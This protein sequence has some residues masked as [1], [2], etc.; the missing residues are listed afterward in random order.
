MRGKV[1]G[2][3]LTAV[4]LRITPAYAGKSFSSDGTSVNIE[5]HP[6]LCGE[7]CQESTPR[8]TTAGSPPPM[9][10]KELIDSRPCPVYRITPAYAGK[11]GVLVILCYF[12]WDPPR[13]CG[14]K[15]QLG[16]NSH[17]NRGSPPP[18]RG[19][20]L[21]ENGSV[22]EIR[23]TPA[24]AGKSKLGSNGC[25]FPVGSP[26]PM[27]GKAS[28]P[29]TFFALPRITPAYAGKRSM[30]L[31]PAAKSWDHPRL[32]GEK[33]HIGQSITLQKGSP[34]PMRGKVIL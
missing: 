17:Q 2:L 19:K 4:L 28:S 34:P 6:R 14:E 27:R 31:F 26:P 21:R 13:L 33:W 8:S 18:M 23:I 9:R 32:C 25:S 5:D 11:S 12:L 7:K 22:Y 16:E 10:G 20:V 1:I 29:L 30:N 15:H 24:Y 3:C